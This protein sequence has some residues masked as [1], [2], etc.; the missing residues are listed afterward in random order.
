MMPTYARLENNTVIEIFVPHGTHT[1]ITDFFPPETA[2]LFEAAPDEVAQ[3]WRR[4]P[5]GTW[6]APP[7]VAPDA[8]PVA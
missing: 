6:Q 4:L 8:D 7:P 2:A 1:E 5:D 3:H